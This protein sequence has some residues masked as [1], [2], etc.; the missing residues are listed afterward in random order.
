MLLAEDVASIQFVI[1]KFLEQMNLDVDVADNGCVAC[2]MAQKSKDE[3]TPYDLILMDIQMPEMNG[4]E[5]TQWLR[6][7][8]W[9]GPIVALT[10]HAMVGDREKCI[11]AGC[12]DYLSKPVSSATLR[13][14]LARCLGQTLAATEGEDGTHNAGDG[15]V[16]L[17]EGGPLSAATVAR[18]IAEFAQELPDRARAIEDALRRRDV[19]RLTELTHQL[20]GSAALYGFAQVAKMAHGIHQGATAEADL[21][22]LQAAVSDLVR[23]CEQTRDGQPGLNPMDRS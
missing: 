3:G 4:Y 5:A 10:A 13:E 1:S 22:P 19:H 15:P 18:L 12:D 8:D 17:L 21:E 9:K 23:L 2:Q 6:Q 16:G 14:V 20:K 7:H 11:R